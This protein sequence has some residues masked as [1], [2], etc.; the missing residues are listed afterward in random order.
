VVLGQPWSE[1][2]SRPMSDTDI[3]A[4][5]KA[6]SQTVMEIPLREHFIS[7]SVN[8]SEPVHVA[9]GVGAK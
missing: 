3:P 4:L 1:E 9:L 7:M 8:S 6:L 2:S 5:L